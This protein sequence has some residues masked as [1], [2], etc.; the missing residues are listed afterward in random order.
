MS[1]TSCDVQAC[2]AAAD[3]C[4][5]SASL[6]RKVCIHV[7]TMNIADMQQACEAALRRSITQSRHFN[8]DELTLDQSGT[9]GQSESIFVIWLSSAEL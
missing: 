4:S 5:R 7:D 6:T 9:V 8:H 2:R 1:D 3:R